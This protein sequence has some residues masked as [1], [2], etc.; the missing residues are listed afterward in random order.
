MTKKND[1]THR[2][3]SISGLLIICVLISGVLCFSASSVPDFSLKRL[4]GST[5]KMGDIIGKKVIIIDFWA[6][7]CKP[8]QKMLKELNTFYLEHR[9]NLE[10]LAISID[11]PS[12]FAKVESYVKGKQ[13]AFTVLLD[14]DSSVARIFT[15]NNRLPFTVIID[16]QGKIAYSHTGYMP[17]FEKELEKITLPLMEN[18]HE[19]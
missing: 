14:P 10:V 16:M 12:A 7:W 17:G 11:D 15:P 9:E 2:R 4:D 13:F 8:C 5:F 3:L 19:E 1:S 18:K 6:I